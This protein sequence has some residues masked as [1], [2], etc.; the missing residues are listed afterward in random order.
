MVLMRTSRAIVST[1]SIA[2]P[3]APAT[4]TSMT[5]TP[6]AARSDAI[7]TFS[8]AEKLTPCASSPSRRVVSRTAIRFTHRS[9]GRTCSQT[10]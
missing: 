1:A 10:T 8:A 2:S 7:A 5:S 3:D 6:L 9:G 4:A